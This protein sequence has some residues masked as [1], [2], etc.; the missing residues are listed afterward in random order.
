M[1]HISTIQT[2]AL[3]PAVAACQSL[4]LAAPASGREAT[5]LLVQLLGL[6]M[7]GRKVVWNAV[8]NLAAIL[9]ELPRRQAGSLLPSRPASGSL[10]HLPQRT[11]PRSVTAQRLQPPLA[12]IVCKDCR[13]RRPLLPCSP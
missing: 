11:T 10:L 12:G 8:G 6:V 2:K 9:D 1:S 3:D 5:G 4:G 13:S 7:N